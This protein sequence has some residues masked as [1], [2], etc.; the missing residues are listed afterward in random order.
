[1]RVT[2][3]QH[4]DYEDAGYAAVR[5]QQRGAEIHTVY[6]HHPDTQLPAIRDVDMLVICGGP[7]GA[8]DS[9][10]YPWLNAEKDFIRAAIDAGCAVL[11]L[12]LGGQM[13]ASA[14]G[15]QVRLNPQPEIGWFPVRAVSTAGGTFPFPHNAMIMNWHY[16]TFDLPAA[17][18]LLASSA[19]CAH[20]AYQIGERVIGLQC[21][22]EMTA[23]GIRY[24]ITHFP[25]ELQP[26]PG[27]QTAAAIEQGIEQYATTANQLM[28]D[29]VDY[30][31][32]AAG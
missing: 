25:Q 29:I 21:H 23:E 15:A 27:I 30:L 26:I 3:L 1:M 7:M 9:A 17:A 4:T 32:D 20:Q 6:M 10:E 13:I 14:L 12:C 16:E 28:A 8:N 19:A 22:P 31:A 5:L 24:L 11:G 2:I 18:T